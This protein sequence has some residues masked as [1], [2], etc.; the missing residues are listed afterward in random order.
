M[1][2]GEPECMHT[3]CIAEPCFRQGLVDDLTVVLG[4]L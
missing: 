4:C 2:F 3:E 1:V